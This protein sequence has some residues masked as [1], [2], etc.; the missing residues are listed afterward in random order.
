MTEWLTIFDSEKNTLGKKLRD[1]VHRDGDWHETFHCWFIEKDDED[2]FLYFQLRSKN[3]KEAPGIW[4]ITSAGHIMHDEDVQIGGLREIEEELG[5]SF[6]TTDLTYKGIYKI[7]YEISNLTDREF[8]HMYF[9]NVIKPLPFA[10]GDEVDD[11]MKVRA[12]AFL[13]LLKREISSF[14]A[15]SVLNNKPI[16]ITFEDIY[17]YDLT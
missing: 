12:T 9:H 1:E 7:D 4:D 3:K 2:M 10:P 6:Q 16:T 13:Q 11:V 15:I 17:P 5:L 8:C 14:S